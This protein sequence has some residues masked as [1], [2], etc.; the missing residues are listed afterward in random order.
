[1]NSKLLEKMAELSLKTGGCIKFDLKAWSLEVY[2]SLCG[3]SNKRTLE[4]FSLIAKQ[5]K[6]RPEPPLLVASTLLVPGYVDV[7]EVS[8]IARFIASLNPEIPYSLLAFHPHFFMQDLPTTSKD[9]AIAGKEAA[10][11]EGLK[12]VKI[13]NLHLLREE[14]Y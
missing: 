4:N 7:K 3:I 8:R 11:K 13:G 9:H 5:T 10:E 2:L 1:M 6:A 12:R 14:S